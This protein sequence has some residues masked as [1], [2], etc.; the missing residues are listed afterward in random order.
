MDNSSIIHPV[1]NCQRGTDVQG[2][3]MS[4]G[5]KC[6]RGKDVQGGQMS[7]GDR[8][9]QANLKVKYGHIGLAI[10]WHPVWPSYMSNESYTKM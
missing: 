9:H 7:K 8:T 5:D 3:Q 10:K 6:T 4:K 2:V 1:G